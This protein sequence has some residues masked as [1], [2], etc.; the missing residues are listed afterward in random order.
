M[1]QKELLQD[2]ENEKNN[3]FAITADMVTEGV[4]YAS[5]TLRADKTIQEHA[6]GALAADQHLRGLVGG[7]LC[8]YTSHVSDRIASK[9]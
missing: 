9:S 4:L 6:G 5:L 8:L 2:F 7:R 1:L 3:T